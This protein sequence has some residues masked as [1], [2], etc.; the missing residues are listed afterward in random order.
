[1]LL[2]RH[3]NMKLKNCFRYVEPRR[4]KEIING[5][6]PGTA[7]D[8]IDEIAKQESVLNTLHEEIRQLRNAGQS[9]EEKE[10]ELWDVQTAL[11]LLARK[12]KS[13]RGERSASPGTS[14][15]DDGPT[16]EM[17]E[18][19]QLLATCTALKEEI[20]RQKTLILDLL[21]DVSKRLPKEVEK[22]EDDCY[23]EKWR[24]E[25]LKEEER[26]VSL[27][28]EISELRRNCCLLR[29]KLEMKALKPATLLITKF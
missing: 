24:A 26:R 5:D 16:L 14:R 27:V 8:V 23:G 15:M 13:L 7:D 28:E 11:T 21:E 2:S 1:M 18:E 29:A 3:W 10:T 12:Q 20:V 17:F 6:F 9:V 25:Y 19:K 22:V 4:P